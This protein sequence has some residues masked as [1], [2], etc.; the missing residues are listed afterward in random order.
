MTRLLSQADG[1][2]Q[3]WE[4]A[5]ALFC[6][7]LD[8]PGRDRQAFL[9]QAYISTPELV[10][11]VRM[12][13]LRYES[14]GSFLERP[15]GRLAPPIG[16]LLT[17]GR[18]LA[19][20]FRIERQLG[21]GGMGEVYAALDLELSEVVALKCLAPELAK[22]AET[23]EYFKKETQL[24]RRITHPNICR[25][26]DFSIDF[27]SEL[28]FLTMELVK[29]ETLA[30]RIMESGPL[31]SSE[32]LPILRQIVAGL[33]AA[34]QAGIIHRDLKPSNI[35]LSPAGA[36]D[37]RVVITDFGL[38]L[39]QRELT[40]KG[41]MA[42][43]PLYMAPEQFTEGMLTPA[44][45]IFA[46]GLV[47]YEMLTG[48]PL[49]LGAPLS[50]VLADGKAGLVPHSR[51]IDVRRLP[52]GW[53][54]AILGCVEPDPAAR[55]Q[56][57]QDVLTALSRPERVRRR[58][59]IAALVGG[60]VATVVWV[61]PSGPRG[62]KSP[63]AEANAALQKGRL[64][65][66]RLLPEEIHKAIAYFETAIRLD[67]HFAAAYSGLADAYSTLDD[68]GGMS[69]REAIDNARA[70]AQQATRLGPDLAEA[71]ASLGL[72]LSLDP[73]RWLSS[74]VSFRKA[75]SLNRDYGPAHQWYGAHLA[76][77][78]DTKSAIEEIRVA[79]R[80]D[81]VSLPISVVLG[82][83]YYYDGQF[84]AAIE[85]GKKTVDLDPNFLYGYILLA[86]SYTALQEYEPALR[87]CQ[88]AMGI[89]RQA[90]PEGGPSPVTVAAQACIEAARGSR[91]K[92]IQ[93]A[94]GLEN[95]ADKEHVPVH[96]LAS[97][98]ALTGDLDLSFG[99]LDRGLTDADPGV[100]YLKVYPPL[101]PIRK[102]PRYAVLLHRL[103]SP[104]SQARSW[105]HQFFGQRSATPT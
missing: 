76:R 1:A 56:R 38:A 12:L 2:A 54:H 86:R 60:A 29:G 95:R 102:D 90:A 52:T 63:V 26:F 34:H 40:G 88:T 6:S 58:A 83:M 87:A 45:D 44:S 3:R 49:G 64:H 4:R 9:D 70:A 62:A 96:Y 74:D 77:V 68:Y 21:A 89:G 39:S 19:K 55:F 82:W 75:I 66:H 93:L 22:N 33:E 61:W 15:A 5:Q 71:H 31:T 92:A 27:E 80:A 72:A 24:A 79:L 35:M 17:T 100:L 73:L 105:I 32:A 85:Q 41:K 99:W 51:F 81:P 50:R 104:E 101:E 43:T 11:Y 98:Y 78:G 14:A 30:H 20:R 53:G 59:A 57:A 25:I 28:H 103:G 65:A 13:L 8:R 48:E 97:I 67:S 10:S 36:A 84:P 46:L 37:A 42:G 69:H 7:A 94:R 23:I 47:A 18:V 16:P 91:A